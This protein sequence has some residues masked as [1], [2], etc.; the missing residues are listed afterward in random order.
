M[1]GPTYTD[2]LV[3]STAPGT[4][5]VVSTLQTLAQQTTAINAAIAAIPTPA[6]DMIRAT[7][8]WTSATSAPTN[9][10][11]SNIGTIISRRW[12]SSKEATLLIPVSITPSSQALTSLTFTLTGPTVSVESLGFDSFVQGTDSVY[13]R[14]VT[15]TAT[16]NQFV[17]NFGAN[18]SSAHTGFIRI[19]GQTP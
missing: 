16:A 13:H 17:I 4:P 2:T 19:E 14:T 1:P 18:N 8:V 5:I 3:T 15:T 12:T 9:V 7:G 11:S 10:A 6:A